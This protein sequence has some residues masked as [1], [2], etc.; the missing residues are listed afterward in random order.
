MHPGESKDGLVKVTRR[1][2]WTD[3]IRARVYPE[4]IDKQPNT[5]FVDQWQQLKLKQKFQALL[6]RW[7]AVHTLQWTS[8][9]GNSWSS[10]WCLVDFFQDQDMFKIFTQIVKI[11]LPL[12]WKDNNG[13]SLCYQWSISI[14]PI[15]AMVLQLRIWPAGLNSPLYNCTIIL[16]MSC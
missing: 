16:M 11:N 13:P 10:A 8:R 15:F 4:K 7:T 1:Q 14:V 5:V 12:P 3:L 2:L 6:N 9:G